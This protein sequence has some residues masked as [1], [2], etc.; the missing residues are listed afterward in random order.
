MLMH[1]LGK[2]GPISLIGYEGL[3]TLKYVSAAGAGL[4]MLALASCGA[5]D[6]EEE[7][8]SRYEDCISEMKDVSTEAAALTI[9]ALCDEKAKAER[10]VIEAEMAA[11]DGEKTRVKRED[12]VSAKD[13]FFAA[14]GAAW[15]KIEQNFGGTTYINDNTIRRSG[16]EVR[17]DLLMH[18]E[19]WDGSPARVYRSYIAKCDEGTLGA[20]SMTV[21]ALYPIASPQGREDY[22]SVNYLSGSGVTEFE[23]VCG[24]EGGADPVVDR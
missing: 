18:R 1:F 17:F 16:S 24:R 6:T 10:A 14:P 20:S 12:G 8:R 13:A 7:V 15:R 4:M 22:A 21:E 19:D 5:P 2:Y 9:K 3:T 11:I 23:D